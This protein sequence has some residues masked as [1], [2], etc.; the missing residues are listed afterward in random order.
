MFTPFGKESQLLLLR[1]TWRS[2]V[3]F[4][5]HH[6]QFLVAVCNSW[7]AGEERLLD[8]NFVD[9]RQDGVPVR[10]RNDQNLILLSRKMLT[11]VTLV[12]FR[13]QLLKLLLYYDR[14]TFWPAKNLFTNRLQGQSKLWSTIQNGWK[15]NT[16]FTQSHHQKFWSSSWYD[17]LPV[18]TN[19]PQTKA[20]I[21]KS[22]FKFSSPLYSDP[23]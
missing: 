7:K 8:F 22:T 16:I 17:N 12:V 1:N 6:I 4:Y 21:I 18:P 20:T 23:P 2:D 9:I 15:K 13:C 19:L 3:L 14:T 10:I 5:C 11:K